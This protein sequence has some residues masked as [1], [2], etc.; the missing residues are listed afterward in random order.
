[1]KVLRGGTHKAVAIWNH[2][3]IVCRSLL[4]AIFLYARVSDMNW[5]FFLG[6]VF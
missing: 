2:I 5:H 6:L 1:M 3:Q 4:L